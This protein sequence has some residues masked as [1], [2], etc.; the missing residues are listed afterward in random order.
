MTR[1]LLF[2]IAEEAKASI[3]TILDAVPE[4]S[5]I[6]SQDCPDD[7]SSLKSKLS[8]DSTFET[9]FIN[10]SPKDVQNW[11]LEKQDTAMFI[12]PNIAGIADARTAKDGTI[13]M[14]WYR[15]GEGEECKPHGVLPPRA[16]SWW[17]FRVKAEQASRVIAALNFVE[18]DVAFPRYFGRKDEFTDGE[19]VFDAEKADRDISGKDE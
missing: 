4:F 5:L 9:A 6:E 7:E 3:P 16:D 13:L 1:T 12:E 14:T 18:P 19:G 11:I 8:P 17:D 2:C 10:S 15:E